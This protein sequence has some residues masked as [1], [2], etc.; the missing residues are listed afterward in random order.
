VIERLTEPFKQYADFGLNLSGELS[1]E[2]T[3]LSYSD[4]EAWRQLCQ[5]VRDGAIKAFSDEGEVPTAI[6]S[7]P[8]SLQYSRPHN[9]ITAPWGCY[10][11]VRLEAAKIA[12]LWPIRDPASPASKWMLEYAERQANQGRKVKKDD[13]RRECIA[14]TGATWRQAEQAYQE[15]PEKY[16]YLPRGPY[17]TRPKAPGT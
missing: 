4:D 1:R 9:E 6:F 2:P 5:A 16:K 12:L 7:N 14:A 3:R 11:H 13:G 8:G 10:H 17:S 15:L